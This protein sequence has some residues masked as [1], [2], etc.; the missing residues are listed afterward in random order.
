MLSSLSRLLAPERLVV[1]SLLVSLV[2]VPVIMATRYIFAAYYPDYVATRVPTIS[3]TSALEPA[4]YLFAPGMTI[5][6]ICALTAWWLV[7]RLNR[8]RIAAADA[9]RLRH[10][11]LCRGLNNFWLFCGVVICLS[12][13]LLAIVTL[14][15]SNEAHMTFSIVLFNALPLAY[16]ADS[17]LE[18]LLS[19]AGAAGKRPGW[20]GLDNKTIFAILIL[21]GTAFYY[22]MFLTKGMDTFGDRMQRQWVYVFTEYVLVTM[23]LSYPAFYYQK[24][25][26]HFARRS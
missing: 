19:R 20:R 16:I 1:S 4:S 23:C 15:V 11:G 17:G 18:V 5:V 9:A 25:K 3:K 14:K 26:Q 7:W 8:D 6:A 21:L 12:L 10:A 2:G 24:L 13:T 22:F